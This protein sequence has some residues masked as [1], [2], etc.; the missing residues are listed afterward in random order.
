MSTLFLLIALVSFTLADA[1]PLSNSDTTVEMAL[2]RRSQVESVLSDHS[3]FAVSSDPDLEWQSNV[4]YNATA[5]L[6]QLDDR[7]SSA[8][9]RYAFPNA[10]GSVTVYVVDSGIRTTHSE[11][12]TMTYS[13]Q[14]TNESR[15]QQVFSDQHFQL[16]GSREGSSSDK[17]AGE[18]AEHGTHVAS[19]VGGL[20]FGVAK[21][22]RM[23]SLE[24]LNCDGSTDASKLIRA[25]EWLSDNVHQPA[26]VVMAIGEVGRIPPLD[27]AIEQYVALIP[28]ELCIVSHASGGVCRCQTCTCGVCESV[29]RHCEL[30]PPVSVPAVLAAVHTAE[31]AVRPCCGRPVSAILPPA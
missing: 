7:D 25:L 24:V 4:Q 5:A 23:K 9:G 3:R 12:R 8:D 19:L 16:N 26:V 18:C 6:R 11:F 13:G 27:R 1:S 20:T 10:A 22:V 28:P 30:H 31:I 17:P 14:N 21:G 29:H 15:V 2:L